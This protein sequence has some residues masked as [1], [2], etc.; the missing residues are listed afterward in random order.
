MKKKAVGII[1]EYNPFHNGHA[2]HLAES[3]AASGA[4]V[5][6]AV[7]S[8]NFTQR[9]EPAIL[10]KWSRARMAC[11]GGVNLVVEMP[12]IFAC[13][14]AG[15]FARAGVE[16]LESLGV[17]CISFGSECG[18][19]GKLRALAEVMD[20]RQ[21]EIEEAVRAACK[22]GCSYPRA[23]A[24]VLSE[25]LGGETVEVPSERNLGRNV[26][27]V[28][29]EPILAGEVTEILSKP[30]NVLA[31]EY[32]RCMRRAQPLT[33]K[34]LG[35]GYN[36]ARLAA[37]DEACE[38]GAAEAPWGEAAGSCLGCK[39]PAAGEPG[40]FASAAGVRNS[41]YSTGCD[42]EASGIASYVPESTYQ[43]LRANQDSI[44]QTE[45]LFPL[46]IQRILTSTADELNAIF[47]AEEGLGNKHKAGV[48]YYKSYEDII[49]DLKSKRYTR[50]RIARI[51]V[52][53]LLGITRADVKSAK[54][55]IRILAFDEKGS[56]YLK[57]I[58]K[59]E[60]SA[61][62]IITNIN[63]EASLYPEI[64]KTLDFDI[65]ATDLYN[66]AARRDLYAGSEYVQHPY[67]KRR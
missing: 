50:T 51:L 48:R 35:A 41:I 21:A 67:S 1:A 54:N 60:V 11:E 28:L 6:V 4:D 8:G 25:M 22:D 55:Y 26:A 42:L 29:S 30:N 44:T 2:Y 5:S 9:G 15:Y 46:L 16:I 57:E 18:D 37:D 19:I 65:K 14:N 63:R 10:D 40:K 7:I 61:L 3:L 64:A 17:S 32:L 45:A 38:S 49:E 59:A 52:M 58:K 13:N 24:E 36:D 62:P 20:A 43:I 34:R 66:L 39:E 12:A 56:E 47:G 23:R 33:I 27:D 31:L 53:T